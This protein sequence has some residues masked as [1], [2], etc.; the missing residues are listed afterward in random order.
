MGY[1]DLKNALCYSLTCD[2][3]NWSIVTEQNRFWNGMTSFFFSMCRRLPTP[4]TPQ[5]KSALRSVSLGSAAL[6][7]EWY[8]LYI[9]LSR[10]L[11]TFFSISSSSLFR[12][13]F[14]FSCSIYILFCIKIYPNFLIFMSCCWL[15]FFCMIFFFNR[16]CGLVVR[17]SGYRYR[18]PAF[19]SRHCQIFLSSSRSGTGSTQPREPPEVNWGA[20]WIKKKVAAPGLENRV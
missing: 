11:F 1:P 7:I 18:G 4:P 13:N 6:C 20:T 15:I 8:V 14:S 9:K 19:D 2:I 12:K 5:A 16:L 17:V 10:S 3:V